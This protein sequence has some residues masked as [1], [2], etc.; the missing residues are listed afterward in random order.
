MEEKRLH[1]R[2]LIKRRIADNLNPPGDLQHGELAFDEG[3]NTLY[4]STSAQDNTPEQ[5]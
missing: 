2:I 3:N 4:I 1:C 5:F